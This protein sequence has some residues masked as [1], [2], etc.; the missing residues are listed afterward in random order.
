M[1]V[2]QRVW[3]QELRKVGDSFN[4][5]CHAG[6]RVLTDAVVGEIQKIPK[7]KRQL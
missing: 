5:L 2:S 6:W 7:E 3:S 4:F 1:E